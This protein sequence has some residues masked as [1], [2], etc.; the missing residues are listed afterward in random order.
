MKGFQAAV[1][2]T[3]QGRIVHG[4]RIAECHGTGQACRK[5]MTP[6]L[7]ISSSSGTSIQIHWSSGQEQFSALQPGTQAYST[8]SVGII[9]HIV[10]VTV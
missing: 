3:F 8:L 4:K 2:P 6:A 10:T 9:R 7:I 5:G 1:S